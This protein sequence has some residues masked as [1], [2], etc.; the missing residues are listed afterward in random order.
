MNKNKTNTKSQVLGWACIATLSASTASAL[1]TELQLGETDNIVAGVELLNK[2][3]TNEAVRHDDVTAHGYA[4]VRWYD[5]GL[6]L[7][8]YLAVDGAI[9][10]TTD[11]DTGETSEVTARLDYLF[12]ITDIAQ[13]IP[14]FEATAYPNDTG[15]GRFHWLGTDG[16][17][18]FPWAEGLEFGASAAYNLN[19]EVETGLH[20]HHW[21]GSVGSRYFWQ[22]AP[23]DMMAWGLLNLGSRSYH[24]ITSGTDNQG[25]T[26]ANIG[27][28]ITL[29][30]PYDAWWTFLRLEGNWW[31]DS[32]DRD[33]IR[34]FGGDPSEIIIGIGA[35]FST[36]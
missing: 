8:G 11:V 5:I 9:S 2:H 7:D 29:P 15:R 25:F 22:D 14:F 10:P 19:D 17:Y 12:E 6:T 32:E 31:L 21:I 3:Y 4:N 13:I 24:E 20:E 23:I 35:E 34:S 36:R 18:M 28:K 26:T 33:S 30:L 27:G 16:W 1:E